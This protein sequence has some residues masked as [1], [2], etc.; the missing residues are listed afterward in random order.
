MRKH[1]A[2]A[3][4]GV[5][6]YAGYPFGMLLVA[7]IVLHKLGASEYGVWMV[8]T[9]LIS[10]GGIIASGFCDANIQRVAL[11]RGTGET[12]SMVHA[13]RSML[14]INLALGFTLAVAVWMAAPFA[15]RHIAASHVTQL[16]E[17]LICVRIASA[18]ILVRAIESVSVSTQ[19][20]FEQY[21]NTTQISTAARLLTLGSAAVLALS[22]FG[23]VSILVATGVFLTLG[24][25]MQFRQLRRFFGTASL[26]PVFEPKE[27]R[28]LMGFGIFSWLQALGSV[29]FGQFDRVI[30]GVS[31][32]ALAVVPYSLCVQFSQP[33]F[34]VTASGLNFLFPYLSGRA[35]TASNRSLKRTLWKAFSCNLL[36]V[37]CGAVL[38]LLFGNRLIELWAGREVARS[39]S[40]ILLPIVLGSALMGLSVT[41]TYAMQALGL[42]RTVAII[43]LSGRAAMLLVMIY[44]LHHLGLQGLA[45]ARVC[46]GAVALLLY[47]PL[48]RRLG[49]EKGEKRSV[50]SMAIPCEVREGSKP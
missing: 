48:V 6:D 35:S 22:G 34:G 17:C 43:S 18:M 29:I 50:S 9:A 37:A 7:P 11:L 20:A 4:Y 12:A 38:V 49:A 42:F 27:T 32:G 33:I 10:T 41:G 30:L 8:A 14:G 23:T 28:V 5:L 1:L 46:Y 2:N 25:Y 44:L 36:L 15:A 16:R 24:T 21:R 31:M 47:V 26:W 19:R 13:V 40:K 3:A 39:A 45:I